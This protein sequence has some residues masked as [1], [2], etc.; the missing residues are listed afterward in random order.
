MKKERLFYLDFVRAVAAVSIIM[1][2]FNARYLYLNPPM[3][4]KAVLTTMVSNIYIGNWGVSLFFIISGAALMYV[5]EEKCDLKIYFKK[6]FLSIYPM[7]WIAY[8]CGF[9]YLFYTNKAVP[10]AGGPKINFIFSILGFDGLLAENIPTFYVLGEW[11]LGA[12]IC[13]YILFPLLRQ[14]I[15]KQPV[16]TWA[17]ILVVY[18]WFMFGYHYNFNVAKIILARLP[19]IVFGMS[20]IKL[21][22]KVD[23]KV[24]LGALAILIINGIA[25]PSWSENIQTTY[26]GILSFLVLVYLSYWVK[27]N[28]VK[29]ICSVIS[30][31][32]YAIFLVHHMVIARMLSTFDLANISRLH[33]YLLFCA[34]CI[35][36]GFFAWA[37]YRVHRSVMAF[38]AEPGK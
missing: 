21:R 3:P 15:K 13:M 24:A 11:F 22:K 10:G 23:W 27:I 25:K 31:Y 30:K 8:I 7:Y 1:T 20:F 36:I 17:V 33:S 2:H 18:A 5:Y 26:V 4:E 29:R 14:G 37:L 9:L 28:I 16:V 34:V 6:R 32:S 35:V 19:E 38:I 12:I